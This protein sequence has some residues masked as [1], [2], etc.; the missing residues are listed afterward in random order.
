LFDRHRRHPVAL[1]FN[2]RFDFTSG[3]KLAVSGQ[4]I[5][6]A[7]ELAMQTPQP[8]QAAMPAAAPPQLVP[9]LAED[10]L[11]QQLAIANASLAEL[12]AAMLGAEAE[13]E[14][15][16]RRVLDDIGRAHKYA[17]ESF[18]Q[19]LLPVR[20]SLEMALQLDTVSLAS[21]KEG[22][23]LTQ[24][25]LDAAFAKNKLIEI[26]AAPGDRLDPV[27]HKAISMLPA[28]QDA[29]TVVSVLQKGYRIGDRLLRPA[30]VTVAQERTGQA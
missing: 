20:D 12:C 15:I 27:L 4:K 17:I 26:D 6:S 16:R 9:A 25:Q 19:A 24:R 3:T 11:A 2:F 21:A 13:L 7:E 22:L 1:D 23:A 30:L 14:H 5:R 28:T 29:T 18:A 8:D 10:T